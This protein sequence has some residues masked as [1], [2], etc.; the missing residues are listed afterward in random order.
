VFLIGRFFSKVKGM[1]GC[2]WGE[3]ALG[4]GCWVLFCGPGS[5]RPAR[6]VPRCPQLLIVACGHAHAC[7][8]PGSKKGSAT[9]AAVRKKWGKP[10]PA[11]WRQLAA[12]GLLVGDRGARHRRVCKLEDAPCLERLLRTR[13]H[14]AQ[15]ARQHG[16][17]HTQN[18]GTQE[19]RVGVWAAHAS[20]SRGARLKPAGMQ[21]VQR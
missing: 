10:P 19:H 7:A 12:H 9:R 21:R 4:V 16:R 14:S 3:C 1:M 20:R 17:E 13:E 8:P 18:T 6:A 11:C 2:V 5:R 15:R